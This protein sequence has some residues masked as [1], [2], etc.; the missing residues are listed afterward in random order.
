MA[1]TSVSKPL[2]KARAVGDEAPIIR[3]SN[4]E[5]MWAAYNELGQRP[6]QPDIMGIGIIY[7]D[8]GRGKTVT[9]DAFHSRM[10]QEGTVRTYSVTAKPTWTTSFMLRDLLVSAGLEPVR[11]SAND[12]LD[13][14]RDYLI[15]RPGVF[16]IDDCET[17][18]RKEPLIQAIRYLHNKTKASFCLIGE[19]K[20]RGILKRYAAFES[21]L[22]D[23]AIV[24]VRPHTL[25][26]VIAV[27]GVRCDFSVS[28]A[29]CREILRDCGESLRMVVRTCRIMKKRVVANGWKSID[30]REY[31]L[32]KRMEHDAGTA[33][34]TEV[35]SLGLAAAGG[36]HA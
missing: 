13:E 2:V 30:T 19:A 31:A 32:I 35:A 7:G 10:S 25:E 14:L 33:R 6:F 36:G 8:P 15:L 23:Q 17:F 11:R 22:N 4:V 12:L 5:R 9:A 27:V 28:D 18:V 20:S 29:V 3:T 24:S 34:P 21:R 1:E 16:L 26:D